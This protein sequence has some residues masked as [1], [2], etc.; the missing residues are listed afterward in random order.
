MASRRLYDSQEF[1]TLGGAPGDEPLHWKGQWHENRHF[2]DCIKEGRQPLTNFA[3][4]AKT[5][6]LVE[7]IHAVGRRGGRR[8]ADVTPVSAS[9]RL[10]E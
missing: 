4:A 6:E 9:A 7:R 10:L 8:R 2:I 3:D 5:M 1:G